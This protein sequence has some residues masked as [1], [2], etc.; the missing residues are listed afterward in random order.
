[1]GRE[2][3]RLTRVRSLTDQARFL[4]QTAQLE[5]QRSATA[6]NVA[7]ALE[8]RQSSTE[9]RYPYLSLAII[10]ASGLSCPAAGARA[11]RVPRAR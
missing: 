7:E 8:R 2:L 6:A 10:P 4:A 3:Q 11:A 9:T 5:V 1:M